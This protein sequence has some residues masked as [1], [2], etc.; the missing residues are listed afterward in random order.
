MFGTSAIEL[1]LSGGEDYQLAFTASK[2][3]VDDLVAN[4]VD[5]TVIGSV[6][7]SELP[8][9]QVDVVDEN[10]ELYEPIHKGWDNLND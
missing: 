9:G 3:L 2:S 6:S 1:A 5:L 7:S 4:K 8:S 10:G